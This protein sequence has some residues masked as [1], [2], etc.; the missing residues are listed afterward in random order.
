[1]QENQKYLAKDELAYNVNH[2]TLMSLSNK[3]RSKLITFFI[4]CNTPKKL[5]PL[6]RHQIQ[7]SIL[8]IQHKSNYLGLGLF[9]VGFIGAKT[10]NPMLASLAAGSILGILGRKVFYNQLEFKLIFDTTAMDILSDKYQFTI[11]DFH[12]SKRESQLAR[13]RGRI[14]RESKGIFN[15]SSK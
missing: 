7:Q 4:A 6:D 11:F 14:G 10:F 13:F 12:N 3:N 8:G 1:M 5:D 15:S 9:T 2:D